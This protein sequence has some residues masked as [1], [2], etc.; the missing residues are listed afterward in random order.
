MGIGWIARNN[1]DERDVDSLHMF[2]LD[3]AMRFPCML[4]TCN[5]L[6]ISLKT[7]QTQEKSTRRKRY[8]VNKYEQHCTKEDEIVLATVV[9]GDQTNE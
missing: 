2:V 6:S 5:L 7:F 4:I 3:N 1:I 8:V 9:I